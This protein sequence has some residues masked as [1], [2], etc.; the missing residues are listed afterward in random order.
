MC[1]VM[2][3]VNDIYRWSLIHSAVQHLLHT[4]E[5]GI[6]VACCYIHLVVRPGLELAAQTALMHLYGNNSVTAHVA[7]N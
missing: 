6:V 1:K 5:P 4:V 7:E 3:Q 2:V